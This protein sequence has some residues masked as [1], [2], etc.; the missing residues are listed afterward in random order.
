MDRWPLTRIGT[1]LGT[2]TIALMLCG[3]ALYLAAVIDDLP[4]DDDPLA[5]IL[6]LMLAGSALFFGITSIVLE[7]LG[8]PVF[9][10][11]ETV[12]DGQEELKGGET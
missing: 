5:F 3:T 6:L 11:A 8:V 1:L 9:R 12:A 7:W 2:T 4:Q 10:K